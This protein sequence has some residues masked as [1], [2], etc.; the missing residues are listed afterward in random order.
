MPPPSN[1]KAFHLSLL[2]NIYFVKQLPE[3]SGTTLSLL[4]G[5]GFFSITRTPEEYSVVG[6]VTDDPQVQFLSEGVPLWRCIK[7]AGPMDPAITGVM[8]NFTIPLKAAGIPIFALSTWNTDYM[9]VPT[10]DAEQAVEVLE[11]DG[12]HFATVP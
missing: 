3:L 11:A 9:L 6:E 7:I 8:C 1:H 5:Q 12:W 10:A 4:N 2:P